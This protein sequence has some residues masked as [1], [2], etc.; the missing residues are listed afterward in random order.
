MLLNSIVAVPS[1][2]TPRGPHFISA[3]VTVFHKALWP[4]YSAQ[5]HSVFIQK[6]KLP[7]GNIVSAI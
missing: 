3:A 1:P 6:H 5:L 2:P 4:L 7:H